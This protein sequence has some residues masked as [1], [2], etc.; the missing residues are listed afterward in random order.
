MDN[1]LKCL[2]E[3]Q[4]TPAGEGEIREGFLEEV[5]HALSLE[6]H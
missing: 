3:H 6:I 5:M 4:V 2:K 1:L